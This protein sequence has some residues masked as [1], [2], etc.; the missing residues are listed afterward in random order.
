MLVS[1]CDCIQN[2]AADAASKVLAAQCSPNYVFIGP[3][4]DQKALSKRTV[5]GLVKCMNMIVNKALD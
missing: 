5:L 2:T 3:I 4:T 1:V